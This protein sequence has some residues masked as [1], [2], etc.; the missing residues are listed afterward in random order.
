MAMRIRDGLAAAGIEV[1][2]PQ[3]DVRLRGAAVNAATDPQ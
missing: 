3:R 1:P 2:L